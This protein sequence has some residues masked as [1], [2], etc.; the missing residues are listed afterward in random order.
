MVRRNGNDTHEYLTNRGR[1]T[2]F[3]SRIGKREYHYVSFHLHTSF[4]EVDHRR[5]RWI[6]A[7][8]LMFL[9]SH[10]GGLVYTALVPG[11]RVRST[12][13]ANIC[14]QR[15]RNTSITRRSQFDVRF[16]FSSVDMTNYSIK[17]WTNIYTGRIESLIFCLFCIIVQVHLPFSFCFLFWRG[18]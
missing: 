7:P 9:F 4:W 15:E 12:R 1:Q 5:L 17:I 13:C 10:P 8:S 3:T 16:F 2:N 14:R 6:D 11:S 18:F